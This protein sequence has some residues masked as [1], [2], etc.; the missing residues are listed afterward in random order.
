MDSENIDELIQK[1]W[2]CETSIEEERQLQEFFATNNVPEHLKES[3]SLFKYFGQQRNR[4]LTDVSFDREV[5][6]K[7]Q[8]RKGRTTTLLYNAMRI[9][10]GVLV[11]MVAIWLVRMEVR[12]TTAPAMEDTY[13][14]PRMAFEE[15]K[16]ALMMISKSFSTAEEHAKK[17]SLFNEAQQDV[18]KAS[19]QSKP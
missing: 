5:L 14:D 6:A 18:K 1:Y 17:I 7:I 4:T 8:P 16:K 10:A 2:R 19:T 12:Q 15:T 13:D 3:A 11:L 9:A